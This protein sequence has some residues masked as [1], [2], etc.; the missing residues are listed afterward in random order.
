MS[1]IEQD[2]AAQWIF[3]TLHGDATLQALVTGGLDVYEGVAPEGSAFPSIVFQILSGR[4]VMVTGAIRIWT[5]LVVLVKVIGKQSSFAAL[6]PIVARID[7]LLHKG[8]GTTSDG[9]TWGSIREQPFRLAEVEN[10]IQYQSSG[11]LYR[12]FVTSS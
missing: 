3:S 12:L 8:S 6:A 1:G 11:G 7:Q 9:Q 2:A 4:D 5:E 10:G